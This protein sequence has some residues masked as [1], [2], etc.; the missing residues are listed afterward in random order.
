MSE[1]LRTAEQSQ[2]DLNES[3]LENSELGVILADA[4]RAATD[5]DPRLEDM[6]IVPIEDPAETRHGFARPAQLSESS[7]HEVHVRLNDLD[8]VLAYYEK[9]MEDYPFSINI[10]ADRLGVAKEEVTPQ[11]LYVQSIL[12]EMGHVTEFMDFEGRMDELKDRNKKERLALPLGYNS[13]TK[14]MDPTSELRQRVDEHWDE[15][16]REHNVSD[17]HGL[18]EIQGVAYRNLTSE[19]VAD[20]FAT[21]VFDVNPQLY[22]QLMLG[23]V[24]AY[25]DFGMAA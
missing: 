7:K 13:L 14:L 22:G 18:A 17:I 6:K 2:H 5:L 20:N 10:I 16:A 12:H 1:V 19:R 24:D 9:A 11:L 25:R 15:L 4:Y 23:D 8:T 21:D 3:L